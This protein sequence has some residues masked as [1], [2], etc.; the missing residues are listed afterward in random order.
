[1][2]SYYYLYIQVTPIVKG[3]TTCYE[4]FPKAAQKVYPICTIRSTPDKPV[5]CIVWAKVR[6]E[7]HLQAKNLDTCFMLYIWIL[8][9]FL[10]NDH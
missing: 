8:I 7:K 6:T 10:K 9:K 5:H 4:C 2:L 3:V 1:M